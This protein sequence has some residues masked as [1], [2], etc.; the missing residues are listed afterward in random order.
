ML[1]TK[2]F[3]FEAAHHLPGHPQCQYNH[4]HSWT[5]RITIEGEVKKEMVMD[6]HEVKALVKSYVLNDL[7]HRDLNNLFKYPSCENVVVWIWERL[8]EPLAM[9]GVKLQEIELC[10]MPNNCITYYGK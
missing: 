1:L 10:E 7:D 5:L 9:S 8:R 6:F 3:T 4:G 2:G